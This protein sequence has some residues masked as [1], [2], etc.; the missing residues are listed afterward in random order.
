MSEIPEYALSR[1]RNDSAK[2][3]VTFTYRLAIGWE[4]A[5]G[6]PLF[7]RDVAAR[8]FDDGVTLVKLRWHR[9]EHEVPVSAHRV[10]RD[11]R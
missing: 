10:S 2:P 8:L 5:E 9:E 4:K 11:P 7:T 1:F 6:K 3:R